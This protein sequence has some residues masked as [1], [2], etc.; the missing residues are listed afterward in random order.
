M[1]TNQST[2]R[3]DPV[4]APILPS[5]QASTSEEA[6]ELFNQL[7]SVLRAC[8]ATDRNHSAIALIHVCIAEGLDTRKRIVGALRHLGFDYR[9]VVKVLELG[10][11]TDPL[12]H[13]WSIDK[14]GTYQSIE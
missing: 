2:D 10:A 12:R 14:D 13:R 1:H 5:S 11:G 8:G 9:H 3:A 6:I 7:R 4:P